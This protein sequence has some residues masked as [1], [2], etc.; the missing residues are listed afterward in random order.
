MRPPNQEG[1]EF[2][3]QKTI[4]YDVRDV[5]IYFRKNHRFD[6][7]RETFRGSDAPWSSS[8]RMFFEVLESQNQSLVM[9]YA[10]PEPTNEIAIRSYIAAVRAVGKPENAKFETL[11]CRTPKP[12]KGIQPFSL[13]A[14]PTQPLVCPKGTISVPKRL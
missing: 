3:G 14:K 2:D 4:G 8:Y 5:K 11:I 1:M 10:V 12:S 7:D 13:P 6:G 9:I